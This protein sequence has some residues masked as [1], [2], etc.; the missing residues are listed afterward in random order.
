[1]LFG[2][3]HDEL[4]AL[5]DCIPDFVHYV[6][7][8]R[9]NVGEHTTAAIKQSVKKILIILRPE[10]TPRTQWS[11]IEMLQQRTVEACIIIAHTS[12]GKWYG[13]KRCLRLS[14][15]TADNLVQH[16]KRGGM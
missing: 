16:G 2:D 11:K 7:V 4:V 1:M 10:T 5:A 12:N 3:Q 13:D 8:Q 6:R 14:L 9:R 15:H